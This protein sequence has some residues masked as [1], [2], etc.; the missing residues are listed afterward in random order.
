MQTAT[1]TAQI[2]REKARGEADAVLIAAE[3]K[4]KAN[5]LLQASITPELIE[6]T[7]VQRWDGVLPS[8]TGGVV[9]FISVK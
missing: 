8:T 2:E 9:P 3:A 1:A 5:N 7:K 6:Y 4:A